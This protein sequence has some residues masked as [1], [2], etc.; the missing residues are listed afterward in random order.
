MDTT[1]RLGV[2]CFATP[3]GHLPLV[4]MSGINEKGLAYHTNSIPEQKLSPRPG[5]VAP[6]EWPVTRMMKAS[7]SVR[8]VLEK[9]ATYN[10]GDSIDYQIHFSDP[11][12][13]AAVIHPGTDGKMTYTRKSN[14]KN[15]FVS[16]NFN[17]ARLAHG[18]WSS[19][20]YR[21][22]DEILSKKMR[23]SRSKK[24]LMASVLEAT[25]QNQ[26]TIYSF[27]YDLRNLK[28]YLYCQRRFE[29]P[30]LLDVKQE[31]EKTTGVRKINLQDL[32][33]L[34]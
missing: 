28:I 7:V 23:T 22:A 16:T 32:I 27:I 9:F 2:V 5:K 18:N 25:H 30:Y 11:S 20:R 10:W 14:A 12:G 19:P 34:D 24:Q 17:M 21:T 6:R 4:L 8:E 13:D 29:S 15:H 3:W 33:S 31:L 26:F 1:G